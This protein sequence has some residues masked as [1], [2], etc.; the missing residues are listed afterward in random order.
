MTRYNLPHLDAAENVFFQRELEMILREQ[1][2]IKYAVLKGKQFVP[3][4][5]SI[6]P[7]AESVTW[8]Q[9]DMA[10]KA[11]RIKD[12]SA[13]LPL[14]NAQGKEFTSPMVSY[15]DAFEYTL[16]ELR[17]A[18]K[19]NRPLERARAMAARK[20]IDQQV[21]AVIATGD[22]D[23][24]LDGFLNRNDCQ[25]QNNLNLSATPLIGETKVATTGAG[26]LADPSGAA[27]AGAGGASSLWVN[28]TA[29]QI[30]ADVN[31]L[32]ANMATRTKDVEHVRR[33]V[34][35]VNPYSLIA[36]TP[37]STISDTTILSF[38]EAAH[39]GVEFASWERLA[40]QGVAIASVGTNRMVGYDPDP[41]NLRVLV[42][43]EFEQLAPQLENFA[44]KVNCRCKMG[45]VISPYPK[46]IIYADGI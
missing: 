5:N 3:V 24:L 6:D 21:D 42:S 28:K 4:D 32:I 41:M 35:P 25:G 2:D 40:L 15:G 16:D 31:L 12:H 17:A 38:L 11:K 8:R 30:I 9:F 14:V 20:V 23:A 39:P 36:S 10:G 29:D 34:I 22:A 45:E 26:N 44:Y 43:I 18:A 13:D 46:S 7:G 19:V 27:D 37:R 33:V 1:F